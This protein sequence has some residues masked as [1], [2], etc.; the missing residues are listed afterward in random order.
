MLIILNWIIGEMEYELFSISFIDDRVEEN[1]DHSKSKGAGFRFEEL[2]IEARKR[3]S[4]SRPDPVR[5]EREGIIWI[6]EFEIC[7]DATYFTASYKKTV[8]HYS[9]RDVVGRRKLDRGT[10]QGKFFYR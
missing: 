5:F 10:S 3:K 4:R 6:P 7:S 9:P 2:A 1:N 8:A